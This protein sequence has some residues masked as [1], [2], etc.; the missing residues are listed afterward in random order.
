LPNKPVEIRQVFFEHFL[1]PSASKLTIQQ[2]QALITALKPFSSGDRVTIEAF[3]SILHKHNPSITEQDA[4]AL[5]IMHQL[6]TQL[7]GEPQ[8]DSPQPADLRSLTLYLV[9][10]LFQQSQRQTMSLENKVKD[11]NVQSDR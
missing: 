2:I 6:A 1:F 3:T 4:R 10:Q 8:I 5:F 7:D 9:V 11:F